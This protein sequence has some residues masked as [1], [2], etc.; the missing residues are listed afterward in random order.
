LGITKI[1][2]SV[3]KSG[4]R[5]K[6]EARIFKLAGLLSIALSALVLLKSAKIEYS[7]NDMVVAFRLEIVI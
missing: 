5:K 2:P 6:I 1:H 4:M 7:G 3:F